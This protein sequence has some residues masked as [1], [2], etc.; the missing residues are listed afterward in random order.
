MLKD[1][2]AEAFLENK[3]LRGRCLYNVSDECIPT[4]VGY[5]DITC[6]RYIQSTEV[7]KMQHHACKIETYK[8]PSTL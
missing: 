8:E 3:A 2:C 7:R 1:F 5:K 4:D 6:I